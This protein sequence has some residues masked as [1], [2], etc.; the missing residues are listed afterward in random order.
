MGIIWRTLSST[1]QSTVLTAGTVSRLTAALNFLSVSSG[2]SQLQMTQQ[3]L[4]TQASMLGLH[5]PS[6]NNYACLLYMSTGTHQ[7]INELVTWLHVH[8]STPPT[9][10]PIIALP[11]WLAAWRI[12]LGIPLCYIVNHTETAAICTVT[13]NDLTL[14]TWQQ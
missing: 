12:R 4:V 3:L 1:A 11:K 9:G 5:T 14:F 8:Q 10:L 13:P 7:Q 6:G 2:L